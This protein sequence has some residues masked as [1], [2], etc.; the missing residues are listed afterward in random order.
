MDELPS[1]LRELT[2]LENQLMSVNQR[3]NLIYDC[4]HR[5]QDLS[6]Q[7]P[8]HTARTK[9][10]HQQLY[11][12]VCESITLSR[13]VIE[14]L[15]GIPANEAPAKKV[16]V[17]GVSVN[18]VPLNDWLTGRTFDDA[19]DITPEIADHILQQFLPPK[20]NPA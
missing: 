13:I 3:H 20:D 2:P 14:L 15:K 1:P 4:F 16:N 9:D 5:L 6:I 10:G 11:D 8:I 12:A 18:G 7:T 17:S 19:A